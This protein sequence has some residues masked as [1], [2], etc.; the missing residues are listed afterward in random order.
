[1][2]EVGAQSTSGYCRSEQNPLGVYFLPGSCRILNPMGVGR[3]QEG[4]KVGVEVGLMRSA[5][6]GERCVYVG[7][8]S[9]G[10]C[11]KRRALS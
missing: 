4:M 7:A 10:V 1:M 2:G 8:M 5:V 11:M 6:K 9:R 3:D